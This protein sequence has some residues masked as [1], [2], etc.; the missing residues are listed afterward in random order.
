MIG[1]RQ[2]LGIRFVGSSAALAPFAQKSVDNTRFAPRDRGQPVAARGSFP[3]RSAPALRG[4]P[5][6]DRLRAFVP[7]G[8][9]RE[10]RWQLARSV[11]RLTL[12]AH[13]G[14]T[15][16]AG[17]LVVAMAPDGEESTLLSHP[18]RGSTARRERDGL[19]RHFLSAA[20][21][22]RIELRSGGKPVACDDV[23]GRRRLHAA[24]VNAC[25]PIE[26]RRE[27]LKKQGRG[28]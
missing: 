6:F 22:Y 3:S 9:S 1:R 26:S 16:G 4:E 8:E 21:D 25:E 17:G 27:I 13:L 20:G 19:H 18:G 5:E 23:H 24:I 28:T 10:A 7:A 2:D 12:T 14:N 11:A 15:R